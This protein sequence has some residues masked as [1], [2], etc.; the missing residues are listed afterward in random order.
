METPQYHTGRCPAWAPADRRT[1][2][3]VQHEVLSI[4]LATTASSPFSFY[5]LIFLKSAHKGMG[6][7]M[8]FS[9][10]YVSIL[11]LG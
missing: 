11:S 7:V 8:T 5:L 10:V 4:L 6:S 1:N 3:Y 9:C 2:C